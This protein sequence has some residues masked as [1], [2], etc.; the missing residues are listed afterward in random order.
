[1]GKGEG[2]LCIASRILTKLYGDLVAYGLINRRWRGFKLALE[3][4]KLNVIGHCN[5]NFWRNGYKPFF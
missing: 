4:W 2:A 3:F 1:M 5:S